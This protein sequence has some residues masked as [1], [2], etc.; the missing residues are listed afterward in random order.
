VLSGRDP[1]KDSNI[2][3]VREYLVCV[4]RNQSPISCSSRVRDPMA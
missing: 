3:L 4:G 1:A 2:A